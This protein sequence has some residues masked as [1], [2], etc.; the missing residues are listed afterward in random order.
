LSFRTICVELNS[1]QV[2]S[3]SDIEPQV[4]PPLAFPSK[5]YL[6]NHISDTIS[7]SS[8]DDSIADPNADAPESES[9]GSGSGSDDDDTVTITP[10]DYLDEADPINHTMW[11]EPSTTPDSDSKPVRAL[12]HFDIFDA[13]TRRRVPMIHLWEGKTACQAYGYASPIT[14]NDGEEVEGVDF[15]GGA[16]MLTSVIMTII[17]ELDRK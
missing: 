4:E 10:G 11:D 1:F 6:P 13:E 16:N 14:M 17:T 8:D 9:E 2:N 7:I 12:L 15:M 5:T 3:D